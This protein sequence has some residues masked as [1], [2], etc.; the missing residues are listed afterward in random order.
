VWLRLPALDPG[1]RIP[2]HDV[3]SKGPQT[4]LPNPGALATSVVHSA[5]LPQ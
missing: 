3:T 1:R 2:R 4:T 5:C